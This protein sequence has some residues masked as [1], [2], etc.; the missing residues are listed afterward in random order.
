MLL[1]ADMSDHLLNKTCARPYCTIEQIG[2]VHAVAQVY[3]KLQTV[4][5]ACHMH[6]LMVE[7]PMCCLGKLTWRAASWSCLHFLQP[8]TLQRH[9]EQPSGGSLTFS[10]A[11]DLTGMTGLAAAAGS[12]S[13]SAASF[14]SS[15]N[16]TVN[17]VTSPI[18]NLLGV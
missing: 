14:Y 10:R 4:H 3:C 17:D 1:P 11:A 12:E 15:T 13:G 18:F 8:L 2:E 7:R 5:P 16:T 6:A 9:L